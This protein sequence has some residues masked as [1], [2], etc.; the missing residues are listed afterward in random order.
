[1][2]EHPHPLKVRIEDKGELVRVKFDDGHDVVIVPYNPRAFFQCWV[3]AY[4]VDLHYADMV[5]GASDS[6]LEVMRHAD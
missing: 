6:A 3:R 5:A 4:P 2:S 1:M